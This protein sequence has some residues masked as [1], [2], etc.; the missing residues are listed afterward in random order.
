MTTHRYY[1][2]KPLD[3]PERRESTCRAPDCGWRL[4]G[5][6][7]A[8]EMAQREH[9]RTGGMAGD[10]LDRLA[11]RESEL[12]RVEFAH[13]EAHDRAVWELTEET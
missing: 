4:T 8:L 11:D 5:T 12:A 2:W 10:E 13:E 7:R 3:D 1:A 6:I 9:S